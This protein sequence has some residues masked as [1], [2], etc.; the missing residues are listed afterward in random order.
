M[1]LQTMEVEA[2][3]SFRIDPAREATEEEPNC[4]C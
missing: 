1:E 4:N 3:R 2:T